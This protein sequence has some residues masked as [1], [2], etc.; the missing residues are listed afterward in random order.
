MTKRLIFVVFL[1]SFL[2]IIYCDF[3]SCLTTTPSDKI[4]LN[5]DCKVDMSIEVLNQCSGPVRLYAFFEPMESGLQSMFFKVKHGSTA[6]IILSR[7]IRKWASSGLLSQAAVTIYA[8]TDLEDPSLEELW[9]RVL[10]GTTSC[11]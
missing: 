7:A 6:S 9:K 8:W 11:A 5:A 4:S 2:Q 10:N 3:P 1:L